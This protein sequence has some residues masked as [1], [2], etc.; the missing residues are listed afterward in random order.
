MA[1]AALPLLLAGAG[2]ASSV[3]QGVS[4]ENALKYNAG[5]YGDEATTAVAQGYQAEATQRR[6]NAAM[7]GSMTAA[8]GQA[9]A[10]YGGSAGRSIDQSAVNAE[11]DALNIR[12]KAG[13]QKWG[14]QQ[15]SN[16]LN[17]EADAVG[18]NTIL[19]AGA[20]LLT[21]TSGGYIGGAD[22]GG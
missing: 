16:N 13:L 1:V 12:Y 15:Q 17:Q 18:R 11:L 21:G 7:L 20:S 9:G 10:G 22:L 6:K 19:K 3:A 8:A 4:Q 5:I 2:A 14:Y